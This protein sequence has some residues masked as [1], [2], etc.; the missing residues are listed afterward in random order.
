MAITDIYAIEHVH[1]TLARDPKAFDLCTEQYLSIHSV[2][3]FSIYERG[4][5]K[6]KMCV[7][8]KSVN[9]AAKEVCNEVR[10]GNILCKS[11]RVRNC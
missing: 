2:N 11:G 6:C 7:L 3:E 10:I 5:L 1:T 9:I 4:C 8:A